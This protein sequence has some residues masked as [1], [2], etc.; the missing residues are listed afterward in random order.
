MNEN[1]DQ[2]ASAAVAFFSAFMGV[3]ALVVLVLLAIT[4][5]LYWRIAE[6]AGYNG[7]WSLLTLVPLGHLVL[8]I[9]FAVSDWPLE[10]KARRLQ[11]A[12]SSRSLTPP[13][14]PAPPSSPPAPMP[15]PAPQTST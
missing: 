8:L 10:V 2:A 4:I 11:V 5:Y 12:L 14:P 7:A 15:P 1:S 3:F 9:L 13:A 6:K